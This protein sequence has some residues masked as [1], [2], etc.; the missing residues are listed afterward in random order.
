MDRLNP[1]ATDTVSSLLNAIKVHSSVFCLSDLGAPW[2]FEIAASTIAKFHLVLEGK[3][4]FQ[5]HDSEAVLL[6]DGDLVLLPRG[7][8]HAMRDEPDSAVISLEQ[9]T[10]D[11]PLDEHA[12]LSNGGP[13]TRTRLLCGGFGLSD[14]S[15]TRWVSRLPDVLVLDS[16]AVGSWSE[17]LV[18]LARLEA[19]RV[20]PGSQ[21]I[22]IKL[23]DVLLSQALRT[24]LNRPDQ[25]PWH[26]VGGDAGIEQ[27]ARQLAQHP[28]WPWTLQ[29][30]AREAGMSRTQLAAGFRTAIGDSPM[31]HLAR[32]RLN[33]AA[34]Y[35]VSSDKSVEAIA[36]RTGYASS[37]SLSKAFRREFGIPP[38]TY[39]AGTL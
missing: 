12:R 28:D 3:C 16:A 1:R 30:L 21:A 13:G 4:W 19:D 33:L 37:A 35:L 25:K 14:T 23:A 26:A 36:R 39:R 38:G 11:H 7:A 6:S 24:Q 17:P 27:A 34:W 20:A 32:I 18:S 5:P 10:S 22:F 29:L 31:R 8:G 9:L 2:G 15:D